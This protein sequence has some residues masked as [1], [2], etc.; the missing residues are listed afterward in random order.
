[1]AKRFLSNQSFQAFNINH[2]VNHKGVYEWKKPP[3]AADM[4]KFPPTMPF[5][6]H[7]TKQWIQPC[8]CVLEKCLNLCDTVNGW[9]VCADKGAQLRLSWPLCRVVGLSQVRLSLSHGKK[10]SCPKQSCCWL[11]TQHAWLSRSLK[12]KFSTW[13]WIIAL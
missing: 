11:S 7:L 6:F 2:P 5:F 10:T 3:Q 9:S 4:E 1:M 12:A 13:V 8:C